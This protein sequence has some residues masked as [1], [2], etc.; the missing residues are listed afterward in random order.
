[1]PN[2]TSQNDH[3]TVAK[4][5]CESV[6][7][8]KSCTPKN[9]FAPQIRPE[10][11]WLAHMHGV[12]DGIS[13]QPAGPLF[14]SRPKAAIRL[15]LCHG[16]DQ[17]GA[18]ACTGEA[19]AQIGVLGHV[20]GVPTAEFLKRVAAKNRVVPP[21]GTTSPSFSIP[22]RSIRNQLAY[23]MVKQRVSHFALSL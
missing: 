6:P 23:S 3:N 19:H 9:R 17:F 2:G 20:M 10:L 14:D 11:S 4:T 13:L 8:N 21:S 22:G 16:V 15:F 7:A 18:V 5:N 12:G 1:M